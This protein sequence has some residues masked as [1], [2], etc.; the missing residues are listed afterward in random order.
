VGAGT[1]SP[2][3]QIAGCSPASAVVA[4]K[5]AGETFCTNAV[6]TCGYADPLNST[7]GVPAGTTLSTTGPCAAY[8]NGGT[9]STN[10]TVVNGCKISGG[11]DIHAKMAGE[12]E[13]D[14]FGATDPDVVLHER[15]EKRAGA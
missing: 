4:T 15:F 8:A 13:R 2:T 9:I 14:L 1:L 12:H 7:A 6:T 3:S 11:L 5:H 10:G